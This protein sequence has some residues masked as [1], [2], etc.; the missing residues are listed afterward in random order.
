[1]LSSAAGS[2][3]G[4]NDTVFSFTDALHK[5]P[6]DSVTEHSPTS[7][8]SPTEPTARTPARI[9]RGRPLRVGPRVGPAGA[10]AGGLQAEGLLH[11][12]RSECAGP[13]ARLVPVAEGV[14]HLLVDHVLPVGADGATVRDRPPHPPGVV[15]HRA[16]EVA[17]VTGGLERERVA[18]HLADGHGRG[19]ADPEVGRTGVD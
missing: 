15:D 14:S 11:H 10:H 8:L 5:S 2:T 12:H 16:S 1:M 18:A 4:G 6:L 7:T 9:P 3:R 19:E 13:G 17:V